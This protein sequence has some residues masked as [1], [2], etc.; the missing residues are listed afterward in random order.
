VKTATAGKPSTSSPVP[1]HEPEPL[2]FP[3]PEDFRR[4]GFFLVG[5]VVGRVRREFPGTEG[6]PTR[7]NITLAIQ[8]ESGLQRAERWSNTPSPS[9]VPQ[10][11]AR[12]ALPVLLTYY[13]GKGGRGAGS[14]GDRQSRGRSF[15]HVTVASRS[16]PPV[17]SGLC[18]EVL[19]H[20]RLC[21][22]AVSRR[23]CPAGAQH[24][25]RALAQ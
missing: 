3:P 14:P 6:K 7:Y 20:A 19:R 22:P 5:A 11:G 16:R 21:W 4:D 17:G 24:P 25:C 13:H 18:R 2:F 10:R 1:A 15:R 12:I 8:T 9:D 23:A